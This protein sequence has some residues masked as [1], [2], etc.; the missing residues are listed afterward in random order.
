L[1]GDDHIGVDIDHAQGSRDAFE[2]G[3]FFHL[4]PA[5][6]RV[7]SSCLRDLFDGV[8]GASMSAGQAEP[9]SQNW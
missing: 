9:A 4:G 8:N 2:N 7:F 6:F 3:E 5:G 1:L